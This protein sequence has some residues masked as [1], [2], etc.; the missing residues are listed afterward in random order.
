MALEQAKKKRYFFDVVEGV[1]VPSVVSIKATNSGVD[2]TIDCP[3]F[4]YQ[5]TANEKPK[6][7]ESKPAPI[8]PVVDKKT[9]FE[10]FV[11]GLE[12]EGKLTIDGTEFR[13]EAIDGEEILLS[14]EAENSITYSMQELFDKVSAE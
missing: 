10:K 12:V 9:P 14:D 13:I 5:E 11:E 2:V 3:V 7:G 8:V 6:K 1:Q 4:E